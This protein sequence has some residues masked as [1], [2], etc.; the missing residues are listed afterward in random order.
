MIKLLR[1]RFFRWIL[2]TLLISGLLLPTATG[3]ALDGIHTYLSLI[4]KDALGPVIAGCEIFPSDNIWNTRV[5]QLPVHPS[6]NEY[7]QTIGPDKEFHAD[8]GSG[9]WNGEPIGIPYG[10][11]SGTQPKVPVSFTY[12]PES[13]PGPYPGP[14]GA[15]IEGGPQADG[16]RHVLILD[17]DQCR[18]YELFSAYPQANGSWKAGS[19]AIFDLRSHALRPSSWTSADAAGLPILPGLVRYDETAAGEIRHAIRFTVPQT[20]R[21]FV[22]PARHFASNITDPS[23][24]PMGQRFRL[25]AD[26]PTAG[27]SPHARVI[28]EAM[29]KYGLILADNGSSWYLSGVPDERWNNKVL[30]E[31][32]VLTGADI[33]AVDVSGLML[34]VNSGQVRQP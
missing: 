29:K 3:T 8:F 18:L 25:R 9:T 33:Q 1:P 20:Q 32:D 2:L 26:Y 7:I 31:L 15:L 5:D 6:S 23:Y 28:A 12:A 21:A 24:P 22:W 19:G 13:D 4:R 11:V 16:D 10:V 17:R 27:F 34:N 30:H 14:P